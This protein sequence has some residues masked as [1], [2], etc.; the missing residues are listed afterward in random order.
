[1]LHLYDIGRLWSFFY[2]TYV[3]L[4][5]YFS[6]DKKYIYLFYL[7]FHNKYQNINFWENK[8]QTLF[9]I[10]TFFVFFFCFATTYLKIT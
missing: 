3:T 6:I 2:D 7:L 1:M 10:N 8:T 5:I 4:G 9:R